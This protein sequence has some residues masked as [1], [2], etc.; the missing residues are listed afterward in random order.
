ME[1]DKVVP[2]AA[3]PSQSRRKPR[4]GS[5]ATPLTNHQKIQFEKHT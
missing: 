1:I 5:Q 2:V 3:S 4:F